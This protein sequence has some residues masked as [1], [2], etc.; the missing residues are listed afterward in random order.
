MKRSNVLK[1]QT[2]VVMAALM[3][4]GCAAITARD[5]SDDARI[6]T[7]VK[8]R[9]AADPLVSASAIDVDTSRGVVSLTGAVAHEQERHRAIQLTQG[10]SG[11]KEIIVRNLVVRR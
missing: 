6:T 10:V 8:S 7:E 4:M 1:A 11:V 5:T 3:L 9:F 2:A